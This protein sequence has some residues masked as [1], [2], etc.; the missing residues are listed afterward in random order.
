M[1]VNSV[2]E[3]SSVLLC[4]VLLAVAV[5]EAR[6]PRFL[7][8]FET[9]GLSRGCAGVRSRVAGFGDAGGRCSGICSIGC[10]AG[11]W[12][13]GGCGAGCIE[14]KAAFREASASDVL[15]RGPGC[16]KEGSS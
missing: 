2:S 3:S 15:C 1:S 6:C 9:R 4:S 10:G 7:F 16:P 13:T 14:L 8:L 12:G 11:F 5:G